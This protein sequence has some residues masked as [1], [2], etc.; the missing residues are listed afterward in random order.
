MK[1]EIRSLFIA[2]ALLTLPILNSQRS[3]AFAEGTTNVISKT[4]SSS[5]PTAPKS[6]NKIDGSKLPQTRTN[7]GVSFTPAAGNENK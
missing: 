2:L 5:S 7:E 1:I 3:T 4:T 6:R